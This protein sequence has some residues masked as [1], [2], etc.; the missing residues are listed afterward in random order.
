MSLPRFLVIHFSITKTKSRLL[1][2]DKTS[3]RMP[4]KWGSEEPTWH[5]A[6]NFACSASCWEQLSSSHRQS[7]VVQVI[8]AWS[9]AAALML[10]PW[11]LLILLSFLVPYTRQ[12]QRGSESTPARVYIWVLNLLVLNKVDRYFAMAVAS[13]IL[14]RVRVHGKEGIQRS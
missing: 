6:S 13:S 10:C 2:Q 14:Q 7:Q 8:P 3:I 4:S 5:L 12:P 1:F 9:I 11:F